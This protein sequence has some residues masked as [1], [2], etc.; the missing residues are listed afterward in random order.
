MPKTRR[1][2]PPATLTALETPHADADGSAE[3]RISP[4]QTGTSAHQQRP[5]RSDYANPNAGYIYRRVEALR[6]AQAE[7]LAD[8]RRLA[9]EES[10]AAQW[11]P[12]VAFDEFDG[13]SDGDL[14]LPTSEFL[15]GV[16]SEGGLAER[17]RASHRA[18]QRIFTSG[19]ES[20]RA[21]PLSSP[22]S[23]VAVV[24]SE[25]R[26]WARGP[27]RTGRRRPPLSTRRARAYVGEGDGAVVGGG[28]ADAVC[29]LFL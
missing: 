26:E 9:A 11:L 15:G 3:P 2:H 21:V 8:A 20:P 23:L 16:E 18:A 19:Y 28:I 22:A 5:P 27:P 25:H 29:D 13:F 6:R 1:P 10:A 7:R 24:T 12:S 14:P 4:A 17:E